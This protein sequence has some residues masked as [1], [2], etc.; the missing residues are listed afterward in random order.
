[1][2]GGI[3]NM[4]VTHKYKVH[5]EHTVRIPT[6][7]IL[8]YARSFAFLKKFWIENVDFNILND[9]LLATK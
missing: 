4:R 2:V 7:S 8:Y 5:N 3:H 6:W 1:M 9:Y